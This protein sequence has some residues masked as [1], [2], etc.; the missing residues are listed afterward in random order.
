[1]TAEV[2]SNTYNSER[3]KADIL[4]GVL[5]EASVRRG[6]NPLAIS[7]DPLLYC[8]TNTEAP[9]EPTHLDD[10]LASKLQN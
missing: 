10:D 6:G 1:M 4:D 7:E 9:K 3:T 5:L 2:C 8:L